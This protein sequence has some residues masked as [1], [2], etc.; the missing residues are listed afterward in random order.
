MVC[1][2][3]LLGFGFHFLAFGH[4]VFEPVAL[5]GD[6]D[7]LRVV[8]K[9]IEDRGGGGHVLQELAPVFRGAVAGHDRRFV[10][11]PAHDDLEE[12]FPGMFGELLESHVVDDEEIG[13]EIMPQDFVALLQRFL[14]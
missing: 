2:T 8:Q 4:G 1:W 5:A 10:F 11:V 7:N 14:R 6:G 12:I 13:L 3:R 9:A